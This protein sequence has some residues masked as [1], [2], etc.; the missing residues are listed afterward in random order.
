[1]RLAYSLSLF[2]L[3]YNSTHEQQVERLIARDKITENEALQRIRAQMPLAEKCRKADI[4][5]DNSEDHDFTL[6]Q[7]QKLYEE[8][9]KLSSHQWIYRVALIIAL[10]VGIA[11]LI[12]IVF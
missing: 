10:V 12:K 3:C 7:V 6:Q 9:R 4:V 2:F 8:M 5:I 11:V 1:M